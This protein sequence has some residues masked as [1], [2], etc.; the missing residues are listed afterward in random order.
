MS[1][2]HACIIRLIGLWSEHRM[3]ENEAANRQLAT[4]EVESV[5]SEYGPRCNATRPA[6]VT[7]V[8][9]LGMVAEILQ[10]LT[11]RRTLREKETTLGWLQEF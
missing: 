11:E 3:N 8:R 4:E 1:I 6:E 10:L 5:A 7:M 2:L 9:A